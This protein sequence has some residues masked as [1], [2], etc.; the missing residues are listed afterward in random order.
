M[1]NETSLKEYSTVHNAIITLGDTDDSGK[2][3]HFKS[4]F[5]QPGV[6][7]YPGQFGNVLITKESLDKFIDTMVGAP[8]II[9]HKNLNNKKTEL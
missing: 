3:R 8:V 9:N 1:Q 2:G 7:G 6:A 5:I 4:R